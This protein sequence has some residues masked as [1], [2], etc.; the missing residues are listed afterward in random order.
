M[1]KAKPNK[2]SLDR[3]KATLKDNKAIPLEDSLSNRAGTN[4]AFQTLPTSLREV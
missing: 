2:V 4:P 1:D 3:T